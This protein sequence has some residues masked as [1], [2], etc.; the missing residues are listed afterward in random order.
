MAS[1]TGAAVRW[2][3]C[4]LPADLVRERLERRRERHDGLSDAT[5]E[6]YLRQRDERGTRQGEVEDGHPVVNTAQNL[7][8]AVR[9]ATDWLRES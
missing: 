8:E 9:R 6:T 3:E 5:W 7:N 2:I 4:E 1:S